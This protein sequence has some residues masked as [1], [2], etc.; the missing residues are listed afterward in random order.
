MQ[1]IVI[2][3][4]AVSAFAAPK[5]AQTPVSNVVNDLNQASPAGVNTLAV[6]MYK[7]ALLENDTNAASEN[8][9]EAIRNRLNKINNSTVAANKT[10]LVLEEIT[11]LNASIALLNN[12]STKVNES[13]AQSQKKIEESQKSDQ[14]NLKNKLEEIAK[15]KQL[16]DSLRKK[17]R[18]IKI[19]TN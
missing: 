17:K 13:I 19:E 18:R 7:K 1:A 6:D 9:T 5:C 15:E 11:K 4:I 16:M 14:A 8:R 2:L 12:E 10:Q 3:I